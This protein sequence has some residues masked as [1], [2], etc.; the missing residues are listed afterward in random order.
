MTLLRWPRAAHAFS[1][2]VFALALVAP[3]AHAWEAGTDGLMP[4]PP[5]SEQVSDLTGTLS[6]AEKRAL[7]AKLAAWERERGTQLAVLIVPTTKPE[8]IESY[9]IRVADAWKIGRKGQDNGAL[10]LVAK[11][12]KKMRIEVGYG[13]EGVL[14][15]ATA[16]RIIAETIAPRFE[17]RQFAQ[18][19]DAGVDQIIAV[20]DKGEP[21]TAKPASGSRSRTG[22]FPIE[23]LLI[24]VFVVVPV[25]GGILRRIFGRA[26]GSTVGA[27]VVAA[28]AWIVAGSLLIA[29]LAAVVALLIM[30]FAGGGGGLTRR[31]GGV[32]LPPAGGSWGG[33]GGGGGFSGGGGGFGG[34]GASG[35]WN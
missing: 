22:G 21:L 28:G 2:L 34:G 12:D 1:V 33:G 29:A 5:L 32:W 8:P 30:L 4:I 3:L 25:M 24:V 10:L 17:Q 31:G 7:E 18:G 15:D 19:I 9:S 11:D 27:G 14:T 20:V 6:P 26:L 16:R 23:M 13:L 35:G